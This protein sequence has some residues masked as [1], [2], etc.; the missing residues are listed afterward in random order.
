[1]RQHHNVFKVWIFELSAIIGT[2]AFFVAIGV[3]L[4]KYDGKEVP[5]WGVNINLNALLALL[6][7]FLRALLVLIVAQVLSQRKWDWYSKGTTRPMVD[8]QRY[9]EASRGSF[10]AIRLLPTVL[11]K[12][13]IALS[14]ALVLLLSFLVGPFVQQASRTVSCSFV[15]QGQNASVPFAHWIPRSGGYQTRIGPG[16]PNVLDDTAIAILSSVT[17]PHGPENQIKSTCATGNCTF[18]GNGSDRLFSSIHTTVGMCNFCTDVTE[19]VK[20]QPG[21]FSAYSTSL[22]NG[23]NIS[24][25]GYTP[26]ATRPSPNLS[27][28]GR[29]LSDE[30]KTISRWAYVNAT[31]LATAR[32]NNSLA[33]VC[34][35]YPCVRSYN[36]SIH[37]N[38]LTENEISTAPMQIE[39][40]P[41]IASSWSKIRQMD[42]HDNWMF[43]HTATIPSCIVSGREWNVSHSQKDIPTTKLEL[44]DVVKDQWQNT[45]RP[46]PCIYRQDPSF[47][48]VITDIMQDEI[49]SGACST[50]KGLTCSKVADR[51]S[52]YSGAIPSLGAG[53][54]LQTLYNKG[55]ISYSGVTDYFDAVALSM[56]NRFRNQY[57][58]ASKRLNDDAVA[59]L[60]L[61]QGIAWQTTVC[62]SARIEWLVLPLTLSIVTALL[63]I[64]V[65]F[66]SWRQR[67][68]KPVWKDSILPFLFYSHRFEMDQKEPHDLST[69]QSTEY[70]AVR[71]DDIA[72]VE[73][74]TGKGA[75][76]TAVDDVGPSMGID[77]MMKRGRNI[78]MRF[79]W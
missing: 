21:N 75:S 38:E 20:I 6:S 53:G 79:R 26:A 63:S 4:K 31:F 36:I 2:I 48:S 1:M 41:A 17:S 47:V 5:D 62:V 37:R 22:P 72:M 46:E 30:H 12:D 35:L 40:N 15:M 64:W 71:G 59:P 27:W 74:D 7:T 69:S 42:T 54:A 19:L 50:R 10:G 51:P 18:D 52:S 70:L 68:E 13:F 8:L 65:I 73:Q 56:T 29:L 24:T 9:D 34:S 16:N 33:S 45:S 78:T 57:G 43:N 60:D 14:A 76:K 32:R 3:I 25:D 77:E 23:L 66:T 58:S 61:V 39:Y 67:G 44:Y 49:F 55:N 28:M 11:W